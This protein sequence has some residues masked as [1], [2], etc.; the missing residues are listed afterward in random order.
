[1]DNY[2]LDIFRKETAE[3]LQYLSL[4]FED[5][6]WITQSIISIID[7]QVSINNTPSYFRFLEASLEEE[8][9]YDQEVLKE[10]LGSILDLD[11]LKLDSLIYVVW[12]L[13]SKV[14]LFKLD[15][16]LNY[17][18]Y[19]WYDSSDEAIILFVPCIRKILL[20]TDHGF[21]KCN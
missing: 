9:R 19:I 6:L 2:K 12:D 5:S 10:D 17:W 15:N 3:E 16:L 21:V 11:S 7:P 4:N 1:M 13:E 14:D 20:V 8:V 18:E